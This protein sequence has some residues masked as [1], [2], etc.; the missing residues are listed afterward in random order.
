MFRIHEIT[1]DAIKTKYFDGVSQQ[2]NCNKSYAKALSDIRYVF[3]SLD[4]PSRMFQEYSLIVCF[5]CEFINNMIQ[6]QLTIT[7][8]IKFLC[9]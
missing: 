4:I 3:H 8:H 5:E 7:K 1:T 6:L 2:L 9:L